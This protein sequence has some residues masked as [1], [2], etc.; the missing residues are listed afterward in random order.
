MAGNVKAPNSD[1]F[2][3]YASP[4]ALSLARPTGTKAADAIN[5]FTLMRLARGGAG[6]YADALKTANQA[7]LDEARIGANTDIAK[8][9]IAAFPQIA[10]K[11][12][13]GALNVPSPYF[14]VD[15]GHA[16]QSD[17]IAQNAAQQSAFGDTAQAIK[18]LTEAGVRPS[19]EDIGAMI[20][21][22]IQEQQ[23]KVQP[24]ISFDS[25]TDRLK[26]QA[27]MVAA[28]RPPSSGGSD[29]D[30]V[31]LSITDDGFG[32]PQY[33]YRGKNPAAVERAYREG[34]QGPQ[35][36]GTSTGGRPIANAR[37]QVAIAKSRGATATASGN[38]VILSFPNG[39]KTQITVNPDGSGV[40]TLVQ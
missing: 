3:V 33:S 16:A 4:Y 22:P 36:V 6:G 23:S 28:N 10:D 17:V 39:R 31:Q 26:A 21:P 32:D 35:G 25:E 37:D 29:P 30:A 19:P 27:A 13:I 12:V 7:A 14:T 5:Q 8:S 18:Y 40:E 38:K 11:G 24:Y 9:Y 15:S 1:V 2:S 34:R 20:T